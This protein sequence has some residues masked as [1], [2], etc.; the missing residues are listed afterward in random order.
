MGRHVAFNAVSAG[1]VLPPTD[2]PP[3]A[4]RGRGVVAMSSVDPEL[5]A[6]LKAA[7]KKKKAKEAAS[8]AKD[9]NKVAAAKRADKAEHDAA[10]KA[11]A[12]SKVAAKAS[13]GLDAHKV[14]VRTMGD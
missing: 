14:R 6:A 5:A 12:A 13:A 8:A 10:Q 3:R 11:A 4:A 1:E 2:E 7:A 9:S